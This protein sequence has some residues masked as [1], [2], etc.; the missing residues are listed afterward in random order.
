MVTTRGVEGGVGRTALM[1]AAARAIEATRPDSLARDGFAR[2]F[3]R[4]ARVSGEWPVH[5]HDV[6]GGAANPLW[7]RL[8]RYF[9]LR[10]RVLDD[11]LLGTGA[12]QVVLLGAGLDSRAFRLAWPPG[13]R[14]FELD[15]PDVLA[16]KRDV[17]NGLG[18]TATAARTTVAVDLRDDWA[19][20]LCGA[21]FDPAVP[22]AWLAEGLLLYLGADT[23]RRLVSAVDRLATP[24]SVL[25]YEVKLAVEHRAS[26]IYRSAKE[27]IGVDLTAL[28]DDG[29]RPDS[30]GALRARGWTTTVRTPFACAAEHGV[31]LVPENEDALASNRWVFA[32]KPAGGPGP[33]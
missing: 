8:G 19:E 20:P 28:F 7:G 1:V 16:F 21:G 3:V 25:A 24:G 13:C 9:G 18:A 17:L 11:F 2:H 14:V 26:P 6:P 31:H 27:Q 32:G 33:P 10:T 30:A 4:S 5:W 22:T 23:E 29:P 15:R 12:A